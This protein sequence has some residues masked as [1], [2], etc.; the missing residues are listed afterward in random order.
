MK[1]IPFAE[2][3][4]SPRPNDDV[5]QMYSEHAKVIPATIN[6]VSRCISIPPVPAGDN[7]NKLCFYTCAL[8]I[9]YVKL[10]Q[11]FV[12]NSIPVVSCMYRV[13]FHLW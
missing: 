4:L 12:S 10:Y 11:I 6:D 2:I 5:I 1:Q 3:E 8:R 9:T 13:E 7:K